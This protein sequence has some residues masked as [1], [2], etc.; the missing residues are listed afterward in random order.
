MIRPFGNNILI[1]PAAKSQVLVSDQGTLCE[2]GK[3]VAIG[4]DVIH[5]KV[6]DSIGFLV[7]GIN[8][9]DVNDEIFYF[10]NESSDFIL[11]FIEDELPEE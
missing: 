4:N 6:G 1:Q 7:W 8:K 3:V 9:L 2:Y 5:V 11:G 10:I